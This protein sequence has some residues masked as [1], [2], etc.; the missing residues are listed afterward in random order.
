MDFISGSAYSI[1]ELFGE[2]TKIVIPDLQRDYCWGD[3][4]YSEANG[5]QPTELVSYFVKNI[6]EIYKNDS[7]NKVTMGIIYGYEQPNNHI[8]ICDG[9]QRLTTIFLLLGYLNY[10][11]KGAFNDYII[12]PKEMN[13]DY[14]P[15]LLYAI[16]ESTLYFLSDLS[17][18]CFIEKKTSPLDIKEAEWYFNEY[19]QDASIQ[20]MIAALAEIN[21]VIS[22]DDLKDLESL[23]RFVLNNLSVLYYDME[24]RSRGEDT[25]I[26]INTTGEPLSASENIKP[27]LLGDP[28]LNEKDRIKY[29]DQWEKREEWFWQNRGDDE[30]T[31]DNGMLDFFIMYW[32]IGLLQENSWVNGQSQKINPRELF[33]H[34]PKRLNSQEGEQTLNMSRY[35]TFKS[36]DNLECYFKALQKLI[37]D[38]SKDEDICVVLND[39]GNGLYEENHLPSTNKVWNWLR[40]VDLCISLPLI[41]LVANQGDSSLLRFSQRLRRNFYD[42]KW[43]KYENNIESRRG[44]NYIDWRYI[45]QI[46]EQTDILNLLT[47][48]SKKL[49]VKKIPNVELHQWYNEDER[50]KESLRE[51]GIDVKTMENNEVLKGDLY[52]LWNPLTDEKFTAENIL[53]RYNHISRICNAIHEDKAKEDIEF[54]NWFR[55][56][57]LISGIVEITHV[58]NCKWNFEGCFYSKPIDTPWWMESS[59]VKELIDSKDPIQFMKDYVRKKTKDFIRLPKDHKELITSW[60]TLKTI[61]ADN[62]SEPYLLS[63]YN[64]RAVSAFVNMENNYIVQRE[65]FHWGN[66]MCGYA[67]K[68]DVRPAQDEWNWSLK[69]NLDS[70]IASLDYISNYMYRNEDI[71]ND[72]NIKKA[73]D[74]IERLINSFYGDFKT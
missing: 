43:S 40:K 24:N 15:H 67:W 22:Q 70:P 42:G 9:Q 12:S 49:Y 44:K 29:S 55:L 33:M 52:A 37:E 64:D 30:K 13:D 65:E 27:I 68:S 71:I 50:K 39:T 18:K 74:E 34:M 63:I 45:I 11:T 41:S 48:D 6:L 51:M 31:S 23:G 46:I 60:L 47:I 72:E 4:A 25:Y 14:E 66:V 59:D 32:Q 56:F 69:K 21:E 2:D 8:Q 7:H 5:K 20:S 38:I 54:S 16:R 3:K 53:D 57:R 26:V 36:L 61:Q 28:L 17:L 10:K 19:D 58:Y 62:N 1:K 35:E 73:D